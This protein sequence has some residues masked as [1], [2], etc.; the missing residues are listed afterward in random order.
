ML[1]SNWVP[2]A[3]Q[4]LSNSK[5]KGPAAG[6]TAV[7]AL[8]QGDNLLVANAGDSRCIVSRRGQVCFISGY[9]EL[10]WHAPLLAQISFFNSV[11]HI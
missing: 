7:V 5:Y 6:C 3:V 10:S 11:K 2:S 9:R 1:H 4:V 8:I